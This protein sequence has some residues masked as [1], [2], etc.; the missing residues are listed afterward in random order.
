MESSI[1]SAPS[2]HPFPRLPY[3]LRLD[4]I[5]ECLECRRNTK[6]YYIDPRSYGSFSYVRGH[7]SRFADIATVDREWKSVVEKGT[8]RSLS[9]R[10]DNYFSPDELDDFQR[11]CV[12]DRIDL[13]S[14]IHLSIC[15]DSPISRHTASSNVDIG[16]T[17]SQGSDADIDAEIAISTSHAERVAN[18]A[19]GQLFGILKNWSRDSEP[20]SFTF[21][22]VD[23]G[24]EKRPMPI[25][26]HLRINSS[27]FPK[28]ACI[29]SFDASEYPEQGIH[30]ES[31]FQLLTRL[32]NAKHATITFEDRNGSPDFADTIQG[33]LHLFFFKW[34]KIWCSPIFTEGRST[35]SFQSFKLKT[36]CLES[37]SMWK[38]R[39]YGGIHTPPSLH[40]SQSVLAMIS[41]LE[42]LYL[43]HM[44]DIPYFLGQS[45]G[46]S[47]KTPQSPPAW[48]NMRVLCLRGQ[49]VRDASEDPVLATRLYDSVTKAL[50]QLPSITRFDVAFN[51]PRYIIDKPGWVNPSVY[52]EVPPRSYPLKM[53]DGT[54]KAANVGLDPMTVDTWKQ[55][56][57]SQWYCELVSVAGFGSI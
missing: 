8:F 1:G 38:Q 44:V 50:P 24:I 7:R 15:L 18:A 57:R 34:L 6:Q 16:Y 32:P 37:A 4:I 33:E 35:V 21:E 55:I 14:S 25:G 13:L 12:G 45:W 56:A 42:E 39:Y 40:L 30:P 9:L 22:L 46:A 31:T 51:T 28:V 47:D 36:L 27:S 29:G 10:F 3:E 53:R 49:S 2:F 11:I 48:P 26:T 54:L 23:R 5:E 41:R 19:F 52:M 17:T 43:L 20:L